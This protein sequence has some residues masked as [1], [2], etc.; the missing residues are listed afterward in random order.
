MLP[1]LPRARRWFD[2]VLEAHHA[3]ATPVMH[4]GFPRLGYCFSPLFLREAKAVV[5]DS[6][7]QPPIEQWGLRD[8][9]EFGSLQARGIT[10]NDTFFVLRP[11]ADNESLFF[12]ELIHVAQSRTLGF[13]RFLVMYGFDLIEFDYHESPL[14]R[15]A[16]ELQDRFDAGENFDALAET[17][18]RT[19]ELAERFR[20]RSPVHR[21]ALAAARFL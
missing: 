10:F 21:F 13:N 19:R 9:P 17:A 8:V 6:T 12:H 14:E 15:M 20:G 3:E 1:I 18:R 2:E 7:P 11:E 16:Y 5:C 4:F